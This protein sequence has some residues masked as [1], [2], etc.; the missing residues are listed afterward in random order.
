MREGDQQGRVDLMLSK[1][2]QPRH[3]EH[4]HMVVELKRPNQKI[5]STILGQI[6]SYAIAV[7]SDERFLQSKTRW[8]FLVVS[9][10]FDEQ[11]KRKARQRGR[12]EGLVYDDGE[13]NIE[14][15]AYEWSEILSNA[16]ATFR[17]YQS[18]FELPSR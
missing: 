9:D 2:I 16:R 4:D 11:T 7:A 18:A 14:V 12:P 8:K 10:E 3:G 17:I 13:L 6:E 5:T 1:T 15:W